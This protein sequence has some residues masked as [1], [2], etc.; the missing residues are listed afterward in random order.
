MSHQCAQCHATFTAGSRV[1]Y[2]SAK[3][4]GRARTLRVAPNARTAAERHA[5]LTC[6]CKFC[7]VQYQNKR[8][9]P[10]GEGSSYCSRGCS[11]AAKAVASSC[12][13]W[14]GKCKG[15]EKNFTSPRKRLYCSD[16][17]F[18]KPDYISVI[19]ESKACRYCGSEFKPGVTGGRPR[20]YCSVNCCEAVQLAAK[21]VA[22]SARKA[23]IRGATVETV[24]PYKVFARDKW[25]CQLCFTKTPKAKRGTYDDDAPEL[26]HIITLSEGGEHSYRN[27]QCACRKCNNAKSGRSMGQLLLI[28]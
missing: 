15:C 25:L 21:R 12:S 19:P 11:F 27:T 1:R 14:F 22:R 17:C 9:R 6:L 3:C 7:G 28:G 13:V 2:C 18:F 8:S 23:L 5:G 10:D 20:E 4:K 26:D 24:D 16:E